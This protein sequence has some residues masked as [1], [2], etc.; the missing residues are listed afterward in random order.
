MSSVDAGKNGV[1]EGNDIVGKDVSSQFASAR[2]VSKQLLSRLWYHF[3]QPETALIFLICLGK[4]LFWRFGV[5]LN[6]IGVICTDN[7]ML[8]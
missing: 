5:L 7:L 6:L 1:M 4:L 3:K 2:V 8:L